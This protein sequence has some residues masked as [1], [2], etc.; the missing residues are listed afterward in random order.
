MVPRLG[1]AGL[2]VAALSLSGAAQGP[3]HEG[4]K[5]MAPLLAEAEELLHHRSPELRGEAAMILASSGIRR[6]HPAILELARDGHPDARLRGI[7]ALGILGAPG[8]EA[9]E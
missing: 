2:L 1:Q 9:H 4:P 7:L 8:S 6:H 5:W 3:G